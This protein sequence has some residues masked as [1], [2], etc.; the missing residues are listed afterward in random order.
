[1]NIS[2]KITLK[3]S[4]QLRIRRNF[5]ICFC[6]MMVFGILCAALC[7]SLVWAQQQNQIDDP[8]YL[9]LDKSISQ[10]VQIQQEKLDALKSELKSAQEAETELDDLY[11]NMTIQITT[12]RNLL[13]LPSVTL[14]DLKTASTEESVLLAKLQKYVSDLNAKRAE[15]D[16]KKKEIKDS[17]ALSEQKLSDIITKAIG[18]DLQKSLQGKTHQLI[19]LFHEQDQVVSQLDG[20]YA[21]RLNKFKA[22]ETDINA[23]ANIFKAK[24]E[25]RIRGQTF[26]R[27]ASPI[28]R[29]MRGELTE[30]VAAVFNIIGQVFSRKFWAPPEGVHTGPYV[31]Y[32]LTLL[33]ILGILEAGL[34]Y[35]AKQVRHITLKFETDHRIWLYTLFFLMENSLPLLGAAGFL[36][37]FPVHPDYRLTPIFLLFP[38]FIQIIVIWLI[39]L[40]AR[41]VIL[42]LKKI[43]DE[44]FQPE[45]IRHLQKLILGFFVF[46][47]LHAVF[48][49]MISYDNILLILLNL[50]FETAF[51][52]W[53]VKLIHIIRSTQKSSQ[54]KAPVV[55][56]AVN[57]L[58]YTIVSG[59]IIFELS[60]FSGL[61]VYW[62]T[63]WVKTTVLFF[64]TFVFFKVLQ[65][66]DAS[67]VAAKTD[68][69]LEDTQDQPYPVRWA[70]IRLLRLALAVGLFVVMP[71]MWG[72]KWTYTADVID[73]LNYKIALGNIEFN[74]MGIIYAGIFI[75]VTHILSVVIKSLLNNKILANK[76]IDT[77]LKES[78]VRITLYCVWGIGFI[79][80]LR[81]IGISATSLTVV[82]GAL[83]IGIGFGLQNIFNNFFSGLILLFERPI[84][85]N[86]VIEINGV[87]G[88]VKEINVRATH[89][90]TYDNADLMIPNSEIIGQ[91]L[92][93]WSFRDPR[94]RRTI[95]VGVAYGS[96]V[97]LV[98]ETLVQIAYNDPRVSRRPHPDVIFADFGDNAL[99]FKLR[100]WAHVDYF[101][102]VESDIRSEIDKEFRKL[103]IQIPF[104]QRDVYI[105]EL[106]QTQRPSSMSSIS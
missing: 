35:A 82:F 61:A 1:M 76:K 49:W 91:Q 92:I 106:H 5:K 93:N 104:P 62:Y 63:S 11:R 105:K 13:I 54:L 50:C 72:A 73:A 53:A 59:G 96:D 48:T 29:V 39:F 9:E 99:I 14:N 33:L 79:I 64:W 95:T 78:I 75:F 46:A 43:A 68:M 41:I 70:V 83:G 103:G 2:L 85:V 37:F 65:E 10:S 100:F 12:Y 84:Q 60:G 8:L 102:R 18:V 87:W 44:T 34:V 7:S 88:V 24:M 25:E 22:I 36:Y 55:R 30:G 31:S 66:L 69:E 20:L 21:D 77:G 16:R 57:I 90:K 98:K 15:L 23:L 56:P 80:I 89:V 19:R 67:A 32:L 26:Q 6:R 81:L 28:L 40:W 58:I 4:R 17:L 27:N 47:S 94:V 97:R 101:L 51:F 52:V 3:D 71:M 74:S 42:I 86:D 38:L 45:L